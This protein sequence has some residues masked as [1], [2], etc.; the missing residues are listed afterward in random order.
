MLQQLKPAGLML[1]AM[2]LLTG[3]IYP[4]ATTGLASM[5]F[6]AQ[7]H[8]SLIRADNKVIGSEWIGQWFDDPK[9]FWPRP[10]ATTPAPYNAASSTGSNLGPMHDD[11]RKSMEARRDALHKADPGNANPIPADLVTSSGSGLDPHISPASA[12][13]QAGRVARVR[14]LS[15]EQVRTAILQAT[16]GR[17][18]GLLGEP[19]VNVLRL[20]LLLDRMK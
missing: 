4:L 12:E 19:R 2:T 20:N 9:Y 18:F 6:S 3:L 5:L 1:I 16:E 15:T 14:G 13:Y 8:G 11:L 10:S 7:A 17:Q